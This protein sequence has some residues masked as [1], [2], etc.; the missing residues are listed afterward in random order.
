MNSINKTRI[1]CNTCVTE[2]NVSKKN[3]KSL[4]NNICPDCYNKRKYYDE[5]LCD[6]MLGCGK[7][8]DKVYRFESKQY[9]KN[10]CNIHRI[11]T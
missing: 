9:C 7:V 3:V 11:K 2:I 6:V 5:H 4:P 1:F 10:C 8:V